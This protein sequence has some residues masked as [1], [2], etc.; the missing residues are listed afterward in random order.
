M[1]ITKDAAL[2]GDVWLV[3]ASAPRVYGLHPE[4]RDQYIREQ[5][6]LHPGR[7]WQLLTELL[8]DPVAAAIVPVT[9]QT[10]RDHAT[11]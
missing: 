6:G 7:Y 10:L 1:N 4:R 9:V 11:S 5:I 3:L 2:H 8:G